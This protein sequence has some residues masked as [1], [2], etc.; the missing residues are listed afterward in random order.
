MCYSRPVVYAY[1]PNFVSIG[2]FCRSLA[3]KTP[4]FAVSWT[5]AFSDVDS[6]WK[7]EK[8]EH[9]AQLQAFPYPAASKL[10]LYSNAFMAKLGAQSLTFK[11]VTDKET[12]K[13]TKN[14]TFLATPA[15][16]EIRAPPNLAR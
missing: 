14:S 16:G 7:S 10:F 1:M 8:V 4:N 9:G 2:L 5:L 11:S 15:A 3:A 12:D 13:Q 6:W